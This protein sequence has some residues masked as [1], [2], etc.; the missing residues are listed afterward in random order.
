MNLG[1]KEMPIACEHVDL[2][3]ALVSALDEL[4]AL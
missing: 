4:L 1:E 2:L 3:A